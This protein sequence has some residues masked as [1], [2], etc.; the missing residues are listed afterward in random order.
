MESFSDWKL[1][2]LTDIVFFSLL[3][4]LSIWLV[5]LS[6]NKI[7]R[8]TFFISVFWFPADPCY[9]SSMFGDTFSLAS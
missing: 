2:H 5:D 3:K 1:F 7:Y 9:S 8:V 6:I 4:F